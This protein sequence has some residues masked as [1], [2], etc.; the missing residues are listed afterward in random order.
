MIKI[1]GMKSCPDCTN[2]YRQVEGNSHYEIIDI[3]AHVKNLKAFLRLRD[4]NAVFDEA[5]RN[6]YAGIPCFVLED[7]TVTLSPAEA[8]IAT[9][10]KPDG[11]SC[12]IDGTGC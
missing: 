9:D 5:K 8:G 10:E 1:Y 4:N 2:V 6:G 11:P 12:N 7:G 3:G